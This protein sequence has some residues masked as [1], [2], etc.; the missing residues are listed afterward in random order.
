MRDWKFAKNWLLRELSRKA[1]GPTGG[2]TARARAP[3]PLSPGGGRG[4]PLLLQKAGAPLRHRRADFE[5]H[6]V[7]GMIDTESR[8]SGLIKGRRC[9]RR[10][11]AISG[12]P[13]AGGSAGLPDW[14]GAKRR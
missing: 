13:P 4:L 14:N 9:S 3:A 6:Y 5:D 2:W 1:V 12:A 8:S 10:G 7:M 11:L